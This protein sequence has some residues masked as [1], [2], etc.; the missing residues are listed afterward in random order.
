MVMVHGHPAASIRIVLLGGF[1][2]VVDGEDEALPEG[3][4]RLVAALALCGRM[5]RSR[6]AG[7]LWPETDERRAMARLRT[8]IW[9]VNQAVPQ[10]VLSAGGH[11]EL[12]RRAH[13]DVHGLEAGWLGVLAGDGPASAGW[14]A[15]GPARLLPDWDDD[16]LV[17]ERERLHQMHLHGLEAAARQLAREGRFGLAVEVALAALRGDPTRESAY[18]TLMSV[19]LA[20]G[21]LSEARRAYRRCEQ[22]LEREL[23]VAPERAT[24]ELLSR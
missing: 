22:V 17:N 16:W 8:G 4:Q 21:N 24:V 10:L 23:G 7:R 19:Y 1:R 2:I 11:L 20:E 18:R 6:L 14:L 3:P 13:V 15:D 9:R 5:S 12:S